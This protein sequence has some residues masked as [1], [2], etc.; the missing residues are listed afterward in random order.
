MVEPNGYDG[1]ISKPLILAHLMNCFQYRS[2][3]A[4]VVDFTLVPKC[5][6]MALEWDK[7]RQDRPVFR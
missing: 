7:V 4:P 3:I 2:L 5:L 1:G 6:I